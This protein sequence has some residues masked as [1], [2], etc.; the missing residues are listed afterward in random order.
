MAES[1]SSFVLILVPLS[2]IQM[3]LDVDVEGR[4]GDSGGADACSFAGCV[5]NPVVVED[6]ALDAN[7]VVDECFERGVYLGGFSGK[8]FTIA[9]IAAVGFEED[10]SSS[11]HMLH[12][13]VGILTLFDMRS[14]C[15]YMVAFSACFQAR[16][17][18]SLF[19]FLVFLSFFMMKF[20]IW[21]KQSTSAQIRSML[22]INGQMNRVL[23]ARISFSQ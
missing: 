14:D 15:L 10:R 4:N 3:L 23:S 7:E 21:S 8:K 20:F 12:D 2:V 1:F 22:Q 16:C 5:T 19:K 17:L 13:A 11:K 6:V 18:V 9:L